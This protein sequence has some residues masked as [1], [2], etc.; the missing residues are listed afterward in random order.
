MSRLLVVVA[1]QELRYAPLRRAAIMLAASLT[2]D[3]VEAHAAGG[4]LALSGPDGI[5]A[6]CCGPLAEAIADHAGELYRLA[7]LCEQ[8]SASYLPS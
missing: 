3:G 2:R 6:D 7:W 4:V 8:T 1:P 5:M